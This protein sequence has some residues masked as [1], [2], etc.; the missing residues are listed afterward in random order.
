MPSGKVIAARGFDDGRGN[1]CGQRYKLA[2]GSIR[3]KHLPEFLACALVVLGLSETRC[4]GAHRI[5]PY[6]RCCLFRRMPAVFVGREAPGIRKF[7]AIT[8]FQPEL[9]A[10]TE[11]TE[12]HVI[13]L[14]HLPHYQNDKGNGQQKKHV[15]IHAQQ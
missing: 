11:K 13:P 7:F 15:E 9:Q 3:I 4:V 10:Q 6:F 2:D 8:G 12:N 5:F 14:G 1:M